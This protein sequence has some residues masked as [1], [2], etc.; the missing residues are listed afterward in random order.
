MCRLVLRN[1]NGK[2]K[3]IKNIW[4]VCLYCLSLRNIDINICM[5]V[6]ELIFFKFI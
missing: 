1:K 6:F 2:F 4:Y 5:V 3:D